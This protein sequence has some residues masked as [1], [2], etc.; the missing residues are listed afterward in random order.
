MP[1]PSR[2]QNLKLKSWVNVSSNQLLANNDYIHSDLGNNFGTNFHFKKN[3][4][5]SNLTLAVSKKNNL[6]FDNSNIEFNLKHV[7]FGL[8]K[9]NRNW[10]FS[11]NTSLILSKNARPS[12]SIYLIKDSSNSSN[13]LSSWIGA[14]SFETFNSILSNTDG[15]QNSMMFGARAVLEPT[16]DLKIELSKTSQ[17]GG[18]GYSSS[19]PS[20]K[21]AILGNTNEHAHKNINQ[22]AGIGISYL[23]PNKKWPLRLYGQLIGEDEAGWLP[24]CNMYLA[25]IEWQNS[26]KANNKFG[27]EIIDTRIDITTNNNCGPNTAYNNGTYKYT[28]Y[29]RVM[30]VPIDTESKSM[31][32]W[33]SINI[34]PNLN[35]HYSLKNL[36]I[37]DSNYSSHRLSSTKES[38]LIGTAGMNWRYKNAQIISKL[39]YKNFNING[40][41]A[42]NTINYSLMTI[43]EF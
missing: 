16:D 32:L 4:I 3:N 12:N 28:N 22:M 27:L 36:T 30:G 20:L 2:S 14:W 39:H 25:G 9:I 24:S 15:P 21:A 23:L 8:G 13:R 19:I 34:S 41:N 38:G 37:N 6:V 17:W 5:S 43:L 35:L 42:N 33:G 29:D 40:N 7:K 31:N 26:K 10:S 1:T 18:S 11:P